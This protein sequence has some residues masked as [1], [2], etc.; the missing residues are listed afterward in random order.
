[1]SH[2]EQAR[3]LRVFGDGR[4]AALNGMARP[5]VRIVRRL[6]TELERIDLQARWLALK[7]VL[8]VLRLEWNAE[9]HTFEDVIS[10][11]YG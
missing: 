1:M 3:V 9:R 4:S 10:C 7:L 11:R 5:A 8:P 6:G 2:I